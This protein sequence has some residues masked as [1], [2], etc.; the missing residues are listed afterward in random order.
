MSRRAARQEPKRLN[1]H[2]CLS[3][4]D[5]HGLQDDLQVEQQRPVA[6]VGEVV[7]DARLHLVDGVGLA[8]QAVH[9][10]EA[11]DARACTLWRIM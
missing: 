7:L 5:H 11:G 3:E 2:S 4:H 1:T 6:Q 10:G 8:A 9:L